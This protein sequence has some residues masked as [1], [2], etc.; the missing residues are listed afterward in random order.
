MSTIFKILRSTSMNFELIS[1]YGNHIKNY[2]DLKVACGYNL[3]SYYYLF[4]FDKFLYSK[5]YKLDYLSE[6]I[7]NEWTSKRESEEK[8]NN[9]NRISMIRNFCEYLNSIGIKAYILKGI[10]SRYK[11]KPYV[12]SKEEIEVLFKTID[13]Y[14]SNMKVN[15]RNFHTIKAYPLLFRLLFLCGLRNNEACTIKLDNIDYKNKKIKI[16]ES[17]NQVDKY[18]YV[19][20]D[21]LNLINDYINNYKPI[22]EWLFPADSMSGHIIK[23][24]VDKFFKTIIRKANI[25]TEDFHPTPHSLRHTYVVHRIDSWIKNGENIDELMPYLSKQ[26]GHKSI[27]E[28]YY[29]YHTLSSSF[30]V[31][32]EKEKN[33]C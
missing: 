16:E 4:S 17:K 29:Y 11:P 5:D 25:G 7:I 21:L 14:F 13:T 33:L 1:Y 12:L 10:S 30:G 3:K 8:N 23:N 19:S 15:N 28:T 18:V 24:S 20:E 26:L 6:E 9:G 31:I 27:E 32:K 22:N 2:L